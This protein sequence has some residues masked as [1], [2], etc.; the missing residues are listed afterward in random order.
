ML[1]QRLPGREGFHTAESVVSTGLVRRNSRAK[2]S[3]ER[4]V[5]GVVFGPVTFAKGQRVGPA[6]IQA[7]KIPRGTFRCL[8]LN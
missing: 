8:S 4:R 6:E 7:E 2:L 1:S 5:D 3:A